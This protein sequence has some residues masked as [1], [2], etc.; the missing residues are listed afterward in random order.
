MA[1]KKLTVVFD[2]S[3]WLS[4]LLQ[5]SNY[6]SSVK[7]LSKIS[8]DAYIHIPEIVLL[9]ICVVLTRNGVSNQ[10]ICNFVSTLTNLNQIQVRKVD[11]L[12]YLNM[13]INFKSKIYA[14]TLDLIIILYV[15]DNKIDLFYTLDK[16]QSTVYNLLIN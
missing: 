16:N 1:N 3:V 10:S 15:L 11:I 5:D 4:L 2:S 12:D 9:E 14:R 7:M 8:T 13:F 6:L